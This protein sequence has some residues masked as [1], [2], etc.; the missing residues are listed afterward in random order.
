MLVS[1]GAGPGPK[2]M[3]NVGK[4]RLHLTVLATVRWSRRRRGVRPAKL[5][6]RRYGALCPPVHRGPR[7]VVCHGRPRAGRLS[8][9]LLPARAGRTGR[10]QLRAVFAADATKP[11]PFGGMRSLAST[12]HRSQRVAQ[13]PA[14]ICGYLTTTV[15]GKVCWSRSMET[16]TVP[17]FTNRRSWTA[18]S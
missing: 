14:R 7:V 16:M 11:R 10:E 6:F 1:L 2:F 9:P 3:I 12:R 18:A 17:G 4:I 13:V 5:R 8:V 15:I